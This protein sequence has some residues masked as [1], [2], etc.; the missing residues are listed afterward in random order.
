MVESTVAS[1]FSISIFSSARDNEPHTITLGLDEFVTLLKGPPTLVEGCPP[2]LETD[3]NKKLVDKLKTGGEAW[4]PAKFKEGTTRKKENVES[5]CALVFDFDKGKDGKAGIGHTEHDELFAY[6]NSRNVMWLAH[7]SFTCGYYKDKYKFRVVLPL[8]SPVNAADYVILWNQWEKALPIKPDHAC[9]DVSR[10]YFS[11]FIPSQFADEYWSAISDCKNLLTF[12]RL[13]NSP[14]LRGVSLNDVKVRGGGEQAHTEEDWLE[15]VRSATEKNP[16]LNKAVYGAVLGRLREGEPL[17]GLWELFEGALKENTASDPVK[18]WG[19]ALAQFKKSQ[20]DAQAL[21]E[22]EREEE[23]KVEYAGEDVLKKQ[24]TNDEKLEG[25]CPNPKQ[26]ASASRALKQ[27]TDAVKRDCNQTQQAAAALGVYCPHVLSED[28]IRRKLTKANQKVGEGELYLTPLEIET[29]LTN[30]ITAGR[31][32]PKYI[33]REGW[34][35]MLLVDAETTPLACDENASIVLEYCPEVANKLR[36]NVRTRTCFIVESVPWS[37]EPIPVEFARED[38][39]ALAM[40][41]A[42]QLGNRP[43][44]NDRAYTA[45]AFAAQKNSYDP[46]FDWLNTLVWDGK[47]RINTWLSDYAGADDSEYTRIVGKRWLLQAV[48]RTHTPACDAQ[49]MLVFTGRTGTGKSSILRELTGED[50]FT[51]D[52]PEIGTKECSF[53]LEKLVIAE[54][55]ELSAWKKHGNA[56]IKALVTNTHEYH[57]E[58]YGRDTRRVLRRAILAGSTNETDYLTDPT[59]NR[60]FWTVEVNRETDF[61]RMRKDRPQIWAELVIMYKAGESWRLDARER[62]IVYPHQEQYTR[63][64][65]LEDELAFFE[66]P[67]KHKGTISAAPGT[68]DIKWFDEQFNE[69]NLFR[70]VTMRQ[71]YQYLQMDVNNHTHQN[72]LRTMLQSKKWSKVKVRVCGVSTKV[73]LVG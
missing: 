48:A 50:Y 73:V 69:Q 15:L 52:L 11:P 16:A 7:D 35:G 20:N 59:G 46:F 29:A 37:D 63:T 43:V 49:G 47:K 5:L 60:R 6:L 70:W 31:A 10:I 39:P 17:S 19:R 51:D 33:G 38:S 40:W 58:S 66:R 41:I 42:K 24:K 62:G 22:K 68:E 54:F 30:G 9:R 2:S 25:F 53:A 67:L 12:T 27:W 8:S 65:D 1:S 36:F 44:G 64:D 23:E 55:S 3:E 21:F 72:R 45:A 18:D 34:K 4:S 13:K 32:R 28:T 14:I 57:R 61:L 71:L 56:L 26:L